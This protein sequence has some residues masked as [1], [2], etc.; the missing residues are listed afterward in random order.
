MRVSVRSLAVVAGVAL[1]LVPSAVAAQSPLPGQSM[2]Q[3]PLPGQSTPPG[4]PDPGPALEDTVWR[5]I[6]VRSGGELIDVPA[7]VDATLT[8]T[9]GQ[10]GGSGGCNQFGGPYALD[11]T[12]V[13]FGQLTTTEMACQDGSMEVETAY[14]Q[15]LGEVAGWSIT[16]GTL[17]LTDGELQPV[18]RF[19]VAPGGSLANVTWTLTGY[20]DATGAMHPPAQGA[21][22]TIEFDDAGRVSG[23][24][25]CNVFNGPYEAD[26][27]FLRIGPLAVT[28]ALCIDPVGAQETAILS[29]F[30]RVAS[31]WASADALEL[32]DDQGAV[33][34]SYASA[35]SIEEVSWVLTT[36]PGGAP[37]ADGTFTT[38]MLADGRL[39]G[40]GPCNNY[41][42]DY[43]LEGPSIRV[44]SIVR[45]ERACPQLEQEDAYL[46]ALLEIASFTHEDNSLVLLGGDGTALLEF[47]MVQR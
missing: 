14:Y 15:G 37:V 10:A 8:L 39:S 17:E 29:A 7:E 41:S 11:G 21:P 30:E 6:E 25:G 18:L 4:S 32:M 22:S 28:M 40:N 20:L 36:L 44:G 45:T 16:D 19:E 27:S 46:A 47:A 2:A 12:L 31:Y 24:T 26:Q 42:G 9:G 1:L 35:A 23:T 5:L 38:L 13:T 3:S 43:T 34:L 33:L